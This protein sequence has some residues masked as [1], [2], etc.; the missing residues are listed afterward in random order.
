[1]VVINNVTMVERKNHATLKKQYG[2]SEYFSHEQLTVFRNQKYFLKE[3][4]SI[5]KYT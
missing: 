3:D 4:D 5:K 2:T 1:M